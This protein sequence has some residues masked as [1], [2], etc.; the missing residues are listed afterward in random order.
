MNNEKKMPSQLSPQC[1]FGN[2][3]YMIYGYI[4]MVAMNQT[5]LNKLSKEH[6]T[7]GYK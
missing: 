1:V 5:V 2:L 7:S 4:L 3:R 6:K